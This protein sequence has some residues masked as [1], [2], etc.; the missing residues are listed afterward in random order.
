MPVLRPLRLLPALL[1]FGFVLMAAA[2]ALA[3]ACA[4]DK[5]CCCPVEETR[6]PPAEM[7]I[8]MA[9]ACCDTHPATLLSEHA[10]VPTALALDVPAL[11][12][13]WTLTQSPPRPPTPAA[14]DLDTGPPPVRPHL[15]FA[16]LLI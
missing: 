5:G 2:P 9:E 3:Y 1:A 6:C 7:P 8:P 11:P 12:V 10:V 14:I 16:V 15:A 4:M 13:L